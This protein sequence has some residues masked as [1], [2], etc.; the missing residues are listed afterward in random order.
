MWKQRYEVSHKPKDIFKNDFQF[1]ILPVKNVKNTA[2]GLT[3]VVLG[4]LVAK[5]RRLMQ[6]P[7]LWRT[8]RAIFGSTEYN[9]KF[10]RSCL[11]VLARDSVSDYLCLSQVKV[12]PETV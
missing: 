4:G 7:E 12:S 2:A 3:P 6:S 9:N 8:E 1:M 5:T 10:Y 11:L